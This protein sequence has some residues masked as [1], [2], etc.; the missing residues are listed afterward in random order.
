[1]HGQ[2]NVFNA[3]TTAANRALHCSARSETTGRTPGIVT[4][5]ISG[6]QQPRR[7]AVQRRAHLQSR[8]TTPAGSRR[9]TRKAP[10]PHGSQAHHR[11]SAQ[12]QQ[13]QLRHLPK[14]CRRA[15]AT[16][17]EK[18]DRR[19]CEFVLLH[20][21]ALMPT[22]MQSEAA[23]AAI[24]AR[25]VKADTPPNEPA[26]SNRGGAGVQVKSGAGAGDAG[27]ARRADGGTPA[28]YGGATARD[29]K[30]GG[31]VHKTLTSGLPRE[32]PFSHRKTVVWCRPEPHH[33]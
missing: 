7:Q 9:R 22:T 4:P 25:P 3:N 23:R 26:F 21:G 15:L 12:C 5:H 28:D 2:N 1:L 32:V 16:K 11:I 13:D 29:I 33:S 17:G 31:I 20:T 19:E 18:F 30:S 8:S 6:S 27:S 14:L 10:S 24:A